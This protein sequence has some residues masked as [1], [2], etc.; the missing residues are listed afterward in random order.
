MNTA[1]R[2]SASEQSSLSR[3]RIQGTVIRA[4]GIEGDEARYCY[5]KSSFVRAGLL[6]ELTSLYMYMYTVEF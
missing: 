2:F 3:P 4:K 1:N 5:T 6:F